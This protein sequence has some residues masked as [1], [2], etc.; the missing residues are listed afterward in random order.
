MYIWSTHICTS[1]SRS[2]G[3]PAGR[4][5]KASLSEG[6]RRTIE[7]QSRLQ[8]LLTVIFTWICLIHICRAHNNFHNQQCKFSYSLTGICVSSKISTIEL[9]I[10]GIQL[11][12]CKWGERTKNVN[13]RL[14]YWYTIYCICIHPSIYFNEVTRSKLL[15]WGSGIQF[16]KVQS[17]CNA[18]R[19]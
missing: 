4:E 19:S 18:L 1:I 6:I 3:P 14:L 10:I 5:A 7:Y 12:N 16:E 11:T 15:L 17:T 8:E 2:W 9:V 13:I